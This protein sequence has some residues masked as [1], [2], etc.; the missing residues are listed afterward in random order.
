[1]YRKLTRHAVVYGLLLSTCSL[2]AQSPGGVG[3]QSLWLQGD[4][5]SGS[6]QTGTLNFNPATATDGI[7]RQ[8][9]LPGNS[10]DLKRATIFTVY[11]SPAPDQDRP[12][13]QMTG[14]FGD[15]LLSTR[16]VSSK[17]GKM[18][19]AFQKT[20]TGFSQ[21]NKPQAIISTYLRRQGLQPASENAEN[22]KAII[23]FGNPVSA[24]LA[25][26][27]PSLTAELIVYE[28]ILKEKEI[29][30]VESYLAIK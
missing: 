13:W 19:M 24:P 7:N 10:K 4:F 5:F 23:Q 14:G 22:K 17:S 9:N 18:K 8:I 29:A 3:R 20:E 16:Q 25:G 27:S 6:A 15:L 1:M 21:R 2:Y 30:R 28:T 11:Q 12:V 26:Q